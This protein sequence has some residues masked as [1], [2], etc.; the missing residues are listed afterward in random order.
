MN[1]KKSNANKKIYILITSLILDI[2]AVCTAAFASY[3][4][5]FI[6]EEQASLDLANKFSVNNYYI[7]FI[8]SVGWIVTLAL[9]GLYSQTNSNLAIANLRLVFRQSVFF[10]FGLGFFSFL[11]KASFSRIIFSFMFVIGVTL[12]I[13]NRLISNVIITRVLFKKKILLSSLVLVGTNSQVIEKYCDWIIDNRYLGYKIVGKI[14]MPNIDLISIGDLDRQMNKTRKVEVLFLPGIENDENFIK[15][16]HYVEDLK[17]HINWIPL[18]SGN[19]GYWK[20][21]AIQ[22]GSPFLTFRTSDISIT[23]KIQKRFFDIIA[24]VVILIGIFPILVLISLAVFFSDGRPIIYSQKRIGRNG[25]P[26]TFYKFRTMV[27]NADELLEKVSSTKGQEHVL[28]KNY[29]DPRVT[30]LGRILRRYSLDELPQFLNVLGG[31][32]SIVGPRPALPKEVVAYDSLYERRLIAKPGITG[33]WQIS[34][35]SDLDMQTSVALDLNYLAQWSFTRDLLI[36]FSTIGAIVKG[37]GA[38]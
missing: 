18:N 5:R 20:I 19:L 9:S 35:R 7:L 1:F 30:K 15:L 38:Y 23:R 31:S 8:V 33:P 24:T 32:M 36:I 25:K 11:S 2:I 6:N 16:L 21:P 10:F 34:G 13:I 26:F 12:L 14:I 22:E 37:K 29:E 17:I 4:F 28:F 3:K 27:K